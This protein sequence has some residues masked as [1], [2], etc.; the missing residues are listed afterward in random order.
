MVTP[1]L[2]PV[3]HA[4]LSTPYRKLALNGTVVDQRGSIFAT[5]SN[6]E[7]R[8]QTAMSLHSNDNTHESY[9]VKKFLGG[10]GQKRT[11][12]GVHQALK[13]WNNVLSFPGMPSVS[14]AWEL[15]VPPGNV[16]PIYR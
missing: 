7:K 5:L 3:H 6:A 11:S 4:L 1:S 15:S 14:S 9:S 16:S 10:G 2:M 13:T 12:T 8:Q